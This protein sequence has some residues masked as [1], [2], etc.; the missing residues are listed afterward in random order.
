M[1][2][3]GYQNKVLRINLNEK[4]ATTEPLRM[5]FAEKY[6]GS[7]GLAIRY[8]Y[9]ELKPGIDALGPEN[10][11]F[12]TTGP[13]S[14]TP[15]P[16][17][18][19]LS[20]A[21]KSPATGTMNDCSIGGHVGVRV[22]FA[23]Y[24]MIIFEGAL[25]GPGYVVIEDDK[26]T[27]EDA[28]SLWG[29]GSHEA[30]GILQSK[31]GIEYS[32]MSIGP[33]GENLVTMSCINSDYYRQAGRGGIGAVMGSKKMKA[34]L[35]KGTGGVKV[36]DIEKA[37]DR[38]LEILHENV[39]LEDNTFVFD[40]GTTAFLEACTDGG[41]VPY[42][43]F[44]EANDPDW[45][46]Y[47]GDVLMEHKVGKRGC[48]S[49]GL[50]CGSFLKIGDAVCEGPEYETIA[51]GGP[52]LGIKNPEAILKFNQVSD[53]MGLDTI[54]AGDTLAWAME[55]TEK[56]L[57]DFG[58]RFGEEEKVPEYLGLMARKEGVGE[59]LALGTK[60]A[61]E[62]LGGTD[63]AMQ[64]KGLEYPQYEPRGSWGMSLCYAVSD[65]GACHMR[66]YAPNEEVFAASIPPYTSEGKGEM[67]F[68]LG[69]GNAIKFSLCICD[70]WGTLSGDFETMAELLRLITGRDW[71]A[72]EME[73]V[74]TRVLHLGRAF[75]QRE[76]FTRKEDTIPKRLVKEVLGRGPG[77]GQKI[78]QEAFEDMLDQYYEVMGWNKDGTLP[79]DLIQS[80]L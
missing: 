33:A 62:K 17:S 63:F 47:N 32:I 26:I 4:K 80:L 40:Y 7:K 28:A 34:I 12:L 48:G 52:N 41:I 23:G 20:V 53:D 3:M 19:K 36:P 8:M 66:A 29:K 43:N 58:I 18:G 31:Y 25:D 6:V 60:L 51:A 78:P 68:K 72:Q 42:K 64:V 16:C 67:V 61:S 69:Q 71:T 22:K 5:D 77:A 74:G 1:T 27:F 37:T 56:G 79:E 45:G 35:I 49:C 75:N 39:L 76:G 2:M 57:Y 50:G 10:K 9:E 30:E 13:L 70:F 46:E 44:S 38:I 14:G 21:A 55:M 11:L 24:D 59:L 73:D 65:R 54:S 15:V